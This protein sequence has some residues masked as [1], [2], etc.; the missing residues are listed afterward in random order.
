M[1]MHTFGRNQG[2][3]A[4]AVIRA[5]ELLHPMAGSGRTKW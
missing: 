4:P 1:I 3:L 5:D 2:G